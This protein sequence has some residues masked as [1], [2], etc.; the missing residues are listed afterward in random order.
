M[1]ILLANLYSI[2]KILPMGQVSLVIPQD[3]LLSRQLQL[4]DKTY[5]LALGQPFS[6]NTLTLPSW[7]NTTWSYLYSWYGFNK[8]GYIPE[9]Y[10]RDQIGMPGENSLKR[11]TQPRQIAFFIMEPVDGIP[12]YVYNSE[13]EAENGKTLLVNE[14]KYDAITLQ[15]RIPK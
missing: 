3:M 4:I 15:Q 13:I 11:T 9:F 7:T 6:I 2:N 10:G 12:L 5:Q 1:L 14:Y 8:Y